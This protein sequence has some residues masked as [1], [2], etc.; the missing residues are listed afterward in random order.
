MRHRKHPKPTGVKGHV[1]LPVDGS[2]PE[3]VPIRFPDTKPEIERYVLEATLRS[4][5]KKGVNL[6]ELTGPP[7]QNAEN[8]LDFTL[9]TRGGEEFLDLM[10]VAPLSYIGGSYEKGPGSYFQGDMAD[11]VIEAVTRKSNKYSSRGSTAVHLLIYSTDWR[12]RLSGG[13]QQLVAFYLHR[14]G[15][16]F[17]SIAYYMPD[18]QETGEV[19]LLCPIHPT[20]EEVERFDATT[21]RGRA[22]LQVDLRSAHL[23]PG[24]NSVTFKIAPPPKRQQP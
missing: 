15:H 14:G 1:V 6:Y 21:L 3:F 17:K 10:E 20:T 8:H 7:I 23:E 4:A 13:T 9:L 5:A 11:A 24:G 2:R 22:I 19:A 16:C 18:D 12:F